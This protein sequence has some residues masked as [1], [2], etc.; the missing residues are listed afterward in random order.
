MSGFAFIG[1][2][3]KRDPKAHYTDPRGLINEW[4]NGLSKR[5]Y[6]AS[7]LFPSVIQ[8]YGQS[9]KQGDAV[10]LV[11]LTLELADNLIKALEETPT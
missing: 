11:T 5:E 8:K 4:S 3:Q 10:T 7:L 9:T 2:T 1:Q 6:F